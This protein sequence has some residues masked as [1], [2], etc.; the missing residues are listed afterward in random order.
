MLFRSGKDVQ[1][2]TYFLMLGIAFTFCFI[3]S[4]IFVILQPQSEK[5]VSK[6]IKDL[7]KKNNQSSV[8]RIFCPFSIGYFLLQIIIGLLVYLPGLKWAD[9]IY[10]NES[11]PAGSLQSIDQIINNS[12]IS[13]YYSSFNTA[14]YTCS[15]FSFWFLLILVIVAI[16][17][18]L[19]AFRSKKND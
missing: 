11:L 17:S 4:I 19:I 6:E 16:Y 2:R 7:L 15:S 18:L 12:F 10:L 8:F 9:Y 5:K 13:K 3:L 14:T 1:R